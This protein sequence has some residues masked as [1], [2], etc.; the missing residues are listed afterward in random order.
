MEQ[1]MLPVVRL[2]L[3]T[4]ASL[5]PLAR[6]MRCALAVVL[7]LVLASARAEAGGLG[8]YEVGSADLGTASAGRAALAEDGSTA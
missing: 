6:A 1:L 5:L 8:L 3:P 4:A 2:G 7:G